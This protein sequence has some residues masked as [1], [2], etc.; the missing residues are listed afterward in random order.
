MS[1]SSLLPQDLPR[2]GSGRSQLCFLKHP[3]YQQQGHGGFPL[4]LEEHMDVPGPAH[5]PP[6]VSASGWLQAGVGVRKELVQERWPQ[7]TQEW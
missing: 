2:E 3:E 1:L 5:H 6:S 7:L 4:G